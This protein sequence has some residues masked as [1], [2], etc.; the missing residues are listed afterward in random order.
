MAPRRIIGAGFDL[1]RKY[2][3][4]IYRTAVVVLLAV[5]VTKLDAVHDTAE[6][7]SRAADEAY[8][9]VQD[10]E[11]SAEE[12]KSSADEAKSACE[13]LRSSRLFR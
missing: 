2:G 4:P 11:G 1:A 8:V 9:V 6:A 13:D 10:L 7:A 5:I 12:A 3:T